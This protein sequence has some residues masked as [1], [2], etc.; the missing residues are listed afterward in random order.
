MRGAPAIGVA[1]AFGLYL[2]MKDYASLAKEA[3][4]RRLGDTA[5]YLGQARPTAVNLFMALERLQKAA[6]AAIDLPN[7]QIINILRQEAESL[8]DEDRRLC[9]AIGENG[10]SLLSP[11]M[12][13]LTHCNAED[14][15]Q[16]AQV[17]L[18]RLF[19]LGTAEV[20]ISR[21]LPM[22]HGRFCK[23]PASPPTN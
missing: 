6:R 15:P 3:F 21:F 9:A 4:F 10:L 14:W 2:A 8:R 19:I 18:W 7:E 11:H 13:L 22:K 23:A 16:Q 5:A 12:R 1:A 20:M 17:R